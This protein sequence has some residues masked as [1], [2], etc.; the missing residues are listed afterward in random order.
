MPTAIE[1]EEYRQR[2]VTLMRRIKGDLDMLRAEALQSAGGEASGGISNVPLH[3]ADLSGRQFEEDVQLGLVANE[4]LLFAQADA[5][6]TRIEEGTFG[7]CENC[8]CEIGMERLDAVPYG[9]LCAA[10][11]AQS[12]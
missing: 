2:L 1:I 10:C 3:K 4:E 11:A 7:S 12:S 9:R 8:Q 5:A 6:L